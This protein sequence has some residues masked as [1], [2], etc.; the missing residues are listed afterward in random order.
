MAE[1]SATEWLLINLKF[2]GKC[3]TCGK[4]ITPGQ[5]LWSKSTKSMKHLECSAINASQTSSNSEKT[6]FHKQSEQAIYYYV[7]YVDIVESSDIQ[8]DLS[9]QVNRVNVFN[10]MI[11]NILSTQK[12]EYSDSTGDGVII[13][14]SD[15]RDAFF[16]SS[17]LHRDILHY[18]RN[19]PNN[20]QPL[21]IRTGI[22]SG[23]S[24]CV[25]RFNGTS[26]PWG[27]DIVIAKRIM[28]MA[29]P[30]QI[31]VSRGTAEQVAPFD[32][33]YIFR[34]M[35][36]H[37][38]KHGEI[39]RVSSFTF[40]DED[41]NLIGN[42]E[43]IDCEC[44][45]DREEGL[46]TFLK[47][48]I[49]PLMKFDGSKDKLDTNYYIFKGKVRAI[50]PIGNPH[51]GE[52]AELELKSGMAL[53]FSFS[54]MPISVVASLVDYEA[55][56]ITS[57][58]IPKEGR[59]KFRLGSNHI[60]T[61]N[62]QIY[63]V[64]PKGLGVIFNKYVRV[65]QG[66]KRHRYRI[67]SDLHIETVTAS[68]K[69]RTNNKPQY[70]IDGKEDTFWSGGEGSW[71]QADLGRTHSVYGFEIHWSKGI[72]EGKGDIYH[73]EVAF[74]NNATKPGRFIRL[75]STRSCEEIYYVDEPEPP[76]G[77]YMRLRFGQ[78]QDNNH[79]GVISLK[80]LG[81]NRLKRK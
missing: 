5:V 46:S 76:D 75:V 25:T 8:L 38:V 2:T 15:P 27:R 55:D 10:D 37:T 70:I 13:S 35:G 66:S 49:A 61:Y 48:L 3:A 31:L 54:T 53:T 23:N 63:T 77:R 6:A 40:N 73:F 67:E 50:D 69:N 62:L 18:N 30:D 39:V 34:P 64:F 52:Q 42:N 11:K 14:F 32:R 33:N 59:N 43:T 80:I 71:I 78:N 24:L 4:E 28:D 41:G 68:E 45:S 29:N 26:A 81:S 9:E 65:R 20:S 17:R 22:S 19:I 72:S 7:L 21:H 57:I 1:N 56:I 51:K 44:H 74:S 36:E 47:V 79:F 12:S 60:S 16:F 58:F